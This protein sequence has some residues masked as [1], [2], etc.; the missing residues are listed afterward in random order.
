MIVKSFVETNSGISWLVLSFDT[1]L[2]FFKY[3]SA[4]IRKR[5][6]VFQEISSN[7]KYFLLFIQEFASKLFSRVARCRLNFICAYFCQMIFGLILSFRPLKR[8]FETFAKSHAI[9]NSARL[10]FITDSRIPLNFL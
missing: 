7:V 5:F 8:M 10:F 3:C 6:V 1:K 9:S 2:W 4:T